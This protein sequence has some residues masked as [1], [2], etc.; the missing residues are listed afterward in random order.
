VRPGSRRPILSGGGVFFVREN[1]RRCIL[2]AFVIE[3]IE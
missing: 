2:P 3:A 1:T